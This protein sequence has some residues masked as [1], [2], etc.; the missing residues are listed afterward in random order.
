MK[1]QDNGNGNKKK[2]YI[3]PEDVVELIKEIIKKCKTLDELKEHLNKINWYLKHE[4]FEKLREVF[5]IDP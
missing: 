5:D 2:V 4:K 3:R 1:M